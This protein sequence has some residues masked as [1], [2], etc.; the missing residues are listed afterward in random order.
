[1]SLQYITKW[2]AIRPEA[3]VGDPELR[4][5][6]ELLRAGELV[7][8][9]TET[10][11]GLG[12]DA[13]NTVAVEGIFRAKGRPSD[14]PLIVHIAELGQLDELVTSVGETERRLIDAFW[15]GPLTLVLPVRPGAV[16]PRV[17]AGLGTV[18]VRMP[19]H[20]AA[21]ALIRAAG[22][23]V[24]APS[25]NRSGRPSPTRA[26]HVR[27][28]LDGA[29]A[30]IVDAGPTGVGLEST[31]AMVVGDEVYV[32][33]PGGVSAEALRACG[34]RV[35]DAAEA[36][37]GG[38]A[39]APEPHRPRSPGMKYAH[40]APKGRL[41]VVHGDD[42][43]RT[44]AWIREQLREAKLRGERTGILTY[45]EHAGN[46]DGAADWVAVCGGLSDLA[47]VAQSLYAA[48]RSFDE[49]HIDYILAEACPS[50]GIG[51]AI[52]NRLRKAAGYSE[53]SL[54]F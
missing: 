10:V 45:A 35:R 52:M 13:R 50:D 40:Y 17:T 25:A 19:A 7:A 31:V 12:A 21:L 34:V 1:M 22:C 28:D 38:A 20:P 42:P 46:Y 33:R 11:Y 8:F 44:A 4:E 2:W 29:I 9:P 41:T 18:A 3:Q 16:S 49:N 36:G 26:E 37:A 30:G 6:A 14:N 39:P 51:V 27:A 15:P 23:P 32:L 53:A 54:D 5:V 24:A 47:T 48:L 43:T